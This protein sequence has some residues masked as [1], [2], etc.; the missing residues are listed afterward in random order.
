MI[1]YLH[2]LRLPILLE[3]PNVSWQFEHLA[4]VL[5]PST[6]LT[7]SPASRSDQCVLSAQLK[8]FWILLGFC[9]FDCLFLVDCFVVGLELVF[10]TG[11]RDCFHK[12]SWQ[13][14]FSIPVVILDLKSL[15]VS[16][17]ILSKSSLVLSSLLFFLPKPGTSMEHSILQTI[18]YL[19]ASHLHSQPVNLSGS[20]YLVC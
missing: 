7:T 2:Y 17:M 18:S 9:L 6:G 11:W 8:A 14:I 4:G 3:M 10:S 12:A 20:S 15:Q 1:N 16:Q 19:L 13:R 5:T